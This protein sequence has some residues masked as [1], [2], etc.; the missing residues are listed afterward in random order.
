MKDKVPFRMMRR[1]AGFLMFAMSVVGCYQ[2]P[3][4]ALHEPHVYKGGQDPLMEKLQQGD[5]RQRL[6]ER[7][8]AVQ[9]DR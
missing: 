5:L 1:A 3:N 8:A 7:F 2:S 6:D 9:T 4:T